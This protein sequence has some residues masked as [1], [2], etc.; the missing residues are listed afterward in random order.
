MTITVTVRA[1]EDLSAAERDRISRLC[2]D[3]NDTA[4]FGDLFVV[5]VRSGGRHF[6]GFDHD[7]LLASHAVVTTRWV[8]PAGYGPQRT[9]FV[10]AVATDPARQRSGLSTHVMRRLGREIDDFDL[11]CLQTDLRSFY[12]RFGWELWR[13]PL[14]GRRDGVA[15]PT[16]EQHGVMVLRLPS[17]PPIDADGQLS[18]EWQPNRFWG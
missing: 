14:A 4:A 16:P 1:T 11:G 3:A 2:N 15:V 18:I 12:E 10:D 9:A 8:Q 13:G 5:Y 7:G 17:T 6:L